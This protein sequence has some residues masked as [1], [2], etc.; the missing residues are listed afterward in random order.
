M[1]PRDFE[2]Q[3]LAETELVFADEVRGIE[4]ANTGIEFRPS[5]I[6]LRDSYPNTALEVVFAASVDGLALRRYRWPIWDPGYESLA[7]GV[8]AITS[9]LLDHVQE[10]VDTHRMVPGSPEEMVGS[11]DI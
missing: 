6:S 8:V 3:L 9:F 5:S 11:I 1:D 10:Y 2:L 7:L 4:K